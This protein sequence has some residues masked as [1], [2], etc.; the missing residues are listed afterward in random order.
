MTTRTPL[1]A[2]AAASLLGACVA[3]D[4]SVTTDELIAPGSDT[5]MP[6]DDPPA[7][8]NG[9]GGSNGDMCSNMICSANKVELNAVAHFHE[10][11]SDEET[12]PISYVTF[13]RGR[14]GLEVVGAEIRV[15]TPH[16]D[17]DQIADGQLA[18]ATLYVNQIGS[19]YELRFTGNFQHKLLNNSTTEF[20]TYYEIMVTR[21]GTNG[22]EKPLCDAQEGIANRLNNTTEGVNPTYA[23]LF[24]GDRFSL[25]GSGKVV[26]APLDGPW[27]NVACAGSPQALMLH[28]RVLT[29]TEPAGVHTSDA[30]RMRIFR[31]LMP[32]QE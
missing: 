28:R 24:K 14:A 18:G 6:G 20:V 7:E 29:V 17:P 1:L 9:G 15:W 19:E 31:T 32:S 26:R 4:I 16:P 2:I 12:T 13:N 25:G 3:P 21:L 11:N 8:P 5:P 27:F 23:T 30:V 22:P 10:L